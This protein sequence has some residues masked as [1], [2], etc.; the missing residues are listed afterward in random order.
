M[1]TRGRPLLACY[2]P[3]CD[4]AIAYDLV[5]VYADCG[6]DN[7]EVGI[8]SEDTAYSREGNYNRFGTRDSGFSACHSTCQDISCLPK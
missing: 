8:L 3:I 7:F 6:V 1:V 5:Q 4:P 2:L